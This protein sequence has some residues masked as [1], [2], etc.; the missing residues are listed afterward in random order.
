VVTR[1]GR[2]ADND[3]V[4]SDADVSRHHAAIIDTGTGFVITDL[5]S[6]NGVEVQRRR[7]RTSTNLTDGDHFR[8]GDHEFTVEISPR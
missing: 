6:A 7:I 3:I 5:R 2:L 1:I 8:I 4:L